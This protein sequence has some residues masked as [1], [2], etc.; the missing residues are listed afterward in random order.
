MQR[1]V[2]IDDDQKEL[3][4]FRGIVGAHYDYITIHWPGESET[5]FSIAAPDIFVSDL[6]LPSASGDAVPTTAQR[7]AASAE[8]ERVAERFSRLYSKPLD[9]K[10]R[11]RE[12]MSAIWDANAM[13]KLQWSAL[14]QSP[15]NGVALLSEVKA[16][17]PDVPFVFYSRKITPEDVIRVLQAGAVDAIRKGALKDEQVLAR[18]AATQDFYRGER[19][20]KI[21][22]QGF[23]AN[24]TVGLPSSQT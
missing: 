23:N 24:I 19:A 10:A 1:L 5:L 22:A 18:L 14:G 6:H 11:L 13:L 20:H 9:D 8:A 2:F 17:F 12:T 4:A 15:D 21:R 3:D 7:D 16:R